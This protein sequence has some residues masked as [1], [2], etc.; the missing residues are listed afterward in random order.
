[1]IVENIKNAF[2]FFIAKEHSLGKKSVIFLSIVMVLIFIEVIFKFSYNVHVN[3]KLNQLSTISSIQ[4]NKL[5]NASE[6]EYLRLQKD[7][8]LNR[9]HY[10]Y[11]VKKYYF[12]L[13]ESINHK[14]KPTN[15]E[16]KIKPKLSIFYTALSSSLFLIIVWIVFLLSPI[17]S[18][19]RAFTDIYDFISATLIIGILVSIITA[20][21]MLFPVVYRPIINYILYFTIQI[22]ILVWIGRKN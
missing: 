4:K 20:V 10:F 13:S 9:Q 12:S 22:I 7:E 21:F 15:I 17:F 6:I 8:I 1:M 16:I 14:A 2:D 3:N 11:Y 5:K 19:H 18:N